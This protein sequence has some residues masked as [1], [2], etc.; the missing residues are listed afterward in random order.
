MTATTTSRK[1]LIKPLTSVIGAEVE[2]LDLRRPLDAETA[3]ELESEL[4]RWKVL[5]LRDQDISF[6][7]HLAFAKHFGEPTAA[8]PVQ[9]ADP[10][11]PE[12]M[13]VETQ[14]GGANFGHGF[15]RPQFGR[16]G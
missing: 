15:E 4:V 14:K 2:G 8:H 3:A 16:R 11:T 5:F 13:V 12:L 10:E 1:L 6:E 9:K 7:Q